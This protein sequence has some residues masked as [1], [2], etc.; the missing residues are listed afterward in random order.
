MSHR[1]D[2]KL[3]T[4]LEHSPAQLERMRPFE[5]W[6]DKEVLAGRFQSGTVVVYRSIWQAW[7]DWLGQHETHWGLASARNVQEFLDGPA[8][9]QRR[10]R[11]PIR[12]D[13][14]ANF[15]KQR[16]WRVLRGVYAHAK[17]LE[18]VNDNPTFDVPE[19]DRPTIEHRGRSPSVLPPGV[20]EN[21]QRSETVTRLV[22]VLKETHWWSVRNRAV[23]SV[24][25]HLG[26]TTAELGSLR[27]CDLRF[28]G[29]LWVDHARGPTQEMIEE[30]VAGGE[31]W[32]DVP[33]GGALQ[34]RSLPVPLVVQA[35]LQG[36]LRA[37]DLLYRQRFFDRWRQDVVGSGSGVEH[38][39]Q[40]LLRS[41]PL[42]PSRKC[43]GGDR[44]NLPGMD[45]VTVFECVQ[46]FLRAYFATQEG[47]V[48]DPR[49]RG[50][51]MGQGAAI[52][53]NSLVAQW[54]TQFGPEEAVIRGGFISHESLRQLSAA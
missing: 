34:A 28:H 12:V 52:V 10:H 31:V 40:A 49:A 42:F 17:R 5:A 14:L 2:M 39:L 35:L 41:A 44:L 36:H 7:T 38:E 6:A 29:M 26:L 13:G 53:R 11:S 24:L 47:E 4:D 19:V 51:Y 27:G 8:P 43:V 18:L 22:P 3:T 33:Q 45:E 54:I 25:T 48:V 46:K 1:K 37:R 9:G 50:V 23:I 15:T 30:G 20:L 16:Y 21:L 32:L